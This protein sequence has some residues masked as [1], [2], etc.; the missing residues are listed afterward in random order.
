MTTSTYSDINRAARR[1]MPQPR[2]LAVAIALSALVAAS[3]AALAHVGPVNGQT[4]VNVSE[5]TQK[6]A[7][8]FVQR[9]G[10]PY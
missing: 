10:L 6:P 3:V 4:N 5:L 8:E 2:Q 9:T 7:P 1:T